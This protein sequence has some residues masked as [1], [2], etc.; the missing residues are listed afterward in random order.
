M[1]V[2]GPCR[3]RDHRSRRGPMSEGSVAAA[4]KRANR[5]EIRVAGHEL[6]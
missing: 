5:I 4:E 1:S 3:K 2:T 6:A